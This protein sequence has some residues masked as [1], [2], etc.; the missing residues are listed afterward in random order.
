VS[1]ATGSAGLLF[2]LV[3]KNFHSGQPTAIIQLSTRQYAQQSRLA[4]IHISQDGNPIGRKTI[5]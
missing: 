3:A 2:V 5:L 1:D 4:R